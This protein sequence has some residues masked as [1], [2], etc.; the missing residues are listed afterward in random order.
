M[1][2]SKAVRNDAGV[3]LINKGTLITENILQ[4]LINANVAYVFVASESDKGRLEEELSALEAR[5]SRTGEKPHM[6]GLKRLLQEHLQ[7]LYS[8]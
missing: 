5:F 7:E 4:K 3:N 8:C 6:A 2:L 1:R